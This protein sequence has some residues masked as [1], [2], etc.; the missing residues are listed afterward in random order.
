MALSWRFGAYSDIGR[1]RK[2][3]DDSAYAGPHLIVVADGMGGAAAGD[4]ASAVA[5]QTLQRLDVPPSDDLLEALAGTLH[6][7][8]DRLAELVDEDPA[9]AGMGTTVTAA[10]F[11]G[12]RIGVAH[13]G[14]SRGYLWRDGELQR[15]T[16]DHTWV[17][18]LIDE[19]RISED[20]AKVHSHR[21]LL[22]KVL[23]GQ[24][25][26][27]PDLTLYDVRDGDRVLLC[28]DGLSGFVG[29][30]RIEHALSVGSA[31]A[32][33]R[34]LTQLALEAGSTDNITVV[35]AD[36]VD[37][38]SVSTDPILVGA[39][40]E[41]TRGA[42]SRLRTWAHRDDAPT[43]KSLLAE[44]DLD[45][46]ELR[47]APREPRRFAG[48]RRLGFLLAL[49]VIAA[50]AGFAAYQWSQHQYYV[51]AY[52]DRVAIYR[53][54]QAD[55][56]GIELHSV[57]QAED[58][59]L[60]ELPSFR[61]S[62]VLDG[63]PA[64]SLDNARRIVG[65][66]RSF[67][68][69]CAQQASASAAVTSTTSVT[70]STK[71]PTSPGSTSSAPPSPRRAPSTSPNSAPGPRTTPHRTQ[72]TGTPKTPRS[73]SIASAPEECAGATPAAAPPASGA[74]TP[75]STALTTPPNTAASTETPP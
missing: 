69:I 54:V 40:T 51:A 74:T 14:D 6:R 64:D 49:A 61:R 70:G 10:L 75:T 44:T 7:A 43:G 5:V 28:S 25:D 47:Y 32:V 57:Y 39:V 60:N 23:D 11:D 3:N 22:L 27:D 48:L 2:K 1:S 34:E 37:T 29:A 72:L 67:A 62:Q 35:V 12:E 68:K 58:V 16:A 19:G 66:L 13:L 31:D 33:A 55:L 50:A 8:N 26:H 73:T 20:E 41:Q 63:M 24:H 65:N 18:S 38:D 42:M 59:H 53:G 9:V 36:V 15:L 4:L 21:S 52:G 45:A 71:T 17:Q 46:E 30:D 56:P